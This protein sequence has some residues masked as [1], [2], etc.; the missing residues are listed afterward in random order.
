M[1]QTYLVRSPASSDYFDMYLC[2][3]PRS[4]MK[5]RL[6]DMRERSRQMLKKHNW[7]K[8][9]PE[10]ENHKAANPFNDQAVKCNE[11]ES[12]LNESTFVSTIEFSMHLLDSIKPSK[13]S[14]FLLF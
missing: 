12:I 6:A 4:A 13:T 2:A 10:P 9:F 11:N 1:N 8:Y 3:S 7:Q 5:K 14:K